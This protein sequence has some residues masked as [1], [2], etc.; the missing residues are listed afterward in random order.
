[1]KPVKNDIQDRECAHCM[2]E[3]CAVA[4]L[5]ANLTHSRIPDKHLHVLLDWSDMLKTTPAEE[6]LSLERLMDILPAIVIAFACAHTYS[7]E[8]NDDGSGHSLHMFDADGCGRM[9]ARVFSLTAMYA[10]AKHGD[11]GRRLARTSACSLV[12]K[13]NGILDSI[14]AQA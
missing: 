10:A 11:E 8:A 14:I 2:S 3:L 5:L 1:M 6:A 12:D 4:P 13:L 9:T 7:V